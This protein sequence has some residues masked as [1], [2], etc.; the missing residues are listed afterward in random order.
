MVLAKVWSAAIVGLD[1]VPVEVEVDI[2]SQGLPSFT[3]VGLPDKAVEEARERVRSA[4][5]NSGAD[6][7]AKRITVNLAPADLPKEGPSYDLPIAI[8]ILIASGQLQAQVTLSLFMGE[9]SLDGRV[10][11]TNGVLSHALLAR[12]RHMRNMYVPHVNATEA[13]CI[14]G[15]AVFPVDNLKNLYLHLSNQI[16]MKALSYAPIDVE[17]SPVTFEHDMKDIKGQEKA[18]RALEIAVAGSHNMLFKGPPGSGKTLLARTAPSILPLP[19]FSEVLE[20]TKIYSISSL[21][22]GGGLMRTRPFRAPHHTTSH[23]GLIGGGTYSKPVDVSFSH[24]G[25]LFLY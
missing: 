4:L 5:K 17:N 22:D 2:A 20:M 8:G 13:T 7:P 23:V 14:A 12:E 24:R 11:H 6:F 19:T 3:I 1:A 25:V 10:R 18:K 9:L 21:L 15:I 16:G